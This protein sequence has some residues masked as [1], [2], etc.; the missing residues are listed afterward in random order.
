MVQ[1]PGQL[2]ELPE[3]VA[4][5]NAGSVLSDEVAHGIVPDYEAWLAVRFLQVALL[6]I[7]ALPDDTLDRNDSLVFDV[8]RLRK[9]GLT[10]RI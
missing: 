8:R 7:Y 10:C 9:R 2:G 3:V 4:S 5:A 1:Y 6:L